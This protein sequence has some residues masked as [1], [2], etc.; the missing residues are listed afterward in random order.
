MQHLPFFYRHL[1]KLHHA[2]TAP[3]PFDDLM[4]HPLEA[5]GYYCILY[6]PA[7]VVPQSVLS[8]FCYMAV[9]GLCGVV[10]HCGIRVRVWG[11]YDSAEHD[12][13]HRLYTCNYSF[14]FSFMDRLHGTFTPP[15]PSPRRKA[16]T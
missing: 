13:H 1:H 11:L 6:A 7:F 3:Q 8:F 14:P 4:I 5:A 2:Y 16:V 12:E 10:D 15:Q 9:I